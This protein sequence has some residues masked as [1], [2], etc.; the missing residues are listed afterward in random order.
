L[1][2]HRFDN[3]GI[4]LVQGVFLRVLAQ[5]GVEQVGLMEEEFPEELMEEELLEELMGADFLPSYCHLK[6]QRQSRVCP[7]P[8]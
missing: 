4:D 2:S 1:W 6:G 8:L 3:E 7:F 5:L